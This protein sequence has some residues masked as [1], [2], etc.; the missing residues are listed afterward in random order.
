M[1]SCERRERLVER[2]DEGVALR[3]P[4]AQERPTEHLGLVVRMRAESEQAPHLGRVDL[5]LDLHRTRAIPDPPP[6]RVAVRVV[7]VGKRQPAAHLIAARYLPSQVL[8]PGPGMQRVERHHAYS[9][10]TRATRRWDQ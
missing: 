5:P 7:V 10:R 2:D 6:G 8:V 3:L 4:T 9:T 1:L